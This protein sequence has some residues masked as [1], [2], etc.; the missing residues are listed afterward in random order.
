[1]ERNDNVS[2]ED[3]E[4]DEFQID[5]VDLTEEVEASLDSAPSTK[6]GRRRIPE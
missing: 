6:R 1:M 5:P 2:I 4:L 3:Q